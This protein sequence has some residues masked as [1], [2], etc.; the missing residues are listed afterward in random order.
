M[1]LYRKISLTFCPDVPRNLKD[2][3]SAD[4]GLGAGEEAIIATPPTKT[5][6]DPTLQCQEG[7]LQP[8]PLPDLLS[9]VLCHLYLTP[10]MVAW[11]GLVT[12]WS[13]E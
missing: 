7:L 6:S 11:Y 1:L 13:V 4:C 2:K 12:S 3:G 5:I 8:C 10:S 9:Q